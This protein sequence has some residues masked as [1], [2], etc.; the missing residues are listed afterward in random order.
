MKL[1]SE[2]VTQINDVNWAMRVVVVIA[3]VLVVVYE[4]DH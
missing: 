1:L 3:L 2:N 4:C